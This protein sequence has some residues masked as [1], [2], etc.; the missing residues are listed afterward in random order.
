M[1]QLQGVMGMIPSVQTPTS[2]VYMAPC[3][4]NNFICPMQIAVPLIITPVRN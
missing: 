1:L 2:L 4:F 3:T